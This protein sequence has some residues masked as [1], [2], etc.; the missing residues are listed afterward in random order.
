MPTLPASAVS[1]SASREKHKKAVPNVDLL[2]LT[3][4]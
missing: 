4:R 2:D 3:N 1:K